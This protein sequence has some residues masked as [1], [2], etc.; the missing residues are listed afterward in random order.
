MAGALV[1]G[2]Y[3]LADHLAGGE[4]ARTMALVALVGVAAAIY[5][6]VILATGAYTLADFKRNALRR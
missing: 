4:V 3:L 2:Q 6:A 5:F 1:G